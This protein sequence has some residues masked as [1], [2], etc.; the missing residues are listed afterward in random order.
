MHTFSPVVQK[1]HEEKYRR[2]SSKA[3]EG[4]QYENRRVCVRYGDPSGVFKD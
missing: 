2:S 4:S 1:I 3:I